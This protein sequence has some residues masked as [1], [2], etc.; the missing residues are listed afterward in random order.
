MAAKSRNKYDVAMWVKSVIESC[1][2]TD[3]LLNASALS[4]NFKEM[5]PGKE[6]S[7][8]HDAVTEAWR[9]AMKRLDLIYTGLSGL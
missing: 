4:N 2:T 8:L 1:K 9:R 6:N 7:A 5:Y 3:Q